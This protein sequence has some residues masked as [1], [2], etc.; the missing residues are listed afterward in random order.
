MPAA[1]KVLIVD[2]EPH[3]RAYV[4]M[5]LQATFAD[6]EILEAENDRAAV[7]VFTRARPD[8][9]LLD[10][11]LVGASGLDVLPRLLAIDPKATVVM[12]TAVNLRRAVED[13]QAKGASG[14]ILKDVDQTEL[15][16]AIVEVVQERFGSA[17][18]TAGA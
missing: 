10:V 18:G 15:A 5:V 1:A 11:N 8:L 4:S 16:A 13:A 14:Y 17:R 9:V 2:D 3:V 7:D 12:L 6:L